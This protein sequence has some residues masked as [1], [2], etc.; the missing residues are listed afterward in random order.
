MLDLATEK[1]TLIKAERDIAEG[2]ARIVR[3]MDLIGNLRERGEDPARA[4]E[5]LH[6]LQDTLD[7][8]KQHRDE[9]V[10]TIARLES[11]NLRP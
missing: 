6:T 2:E 7:A 3:Q 1:Q 4:E 10:L 11:G 5:L 9:I 8:W